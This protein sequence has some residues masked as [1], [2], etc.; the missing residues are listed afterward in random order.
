MDTG[1][2]AKTRVRSGCLTCRAR[3]IKCDESKPECHR[4]RASHV[5]CLGY[6]QKRRVVAAR[7]RA[8]RTWPPEG[9][10]DTVQH[11]RDKDSNESHVSLSALHGSTGLPLVCLPSNPLPY[12]RPHDSARHILA[13]HQYIFRTVSVLAPPAHLFWWRDYL[14]QQAWELEHLYN[15]II[16]LGTIHRAVVLASGEPPAS[17]RHGQDTTINAIRTYTKAPEQLA[18]F[19]GENGP[20]ISTVATT[21]LLAYFEVCIQRLTCQVQCIEAKSS[22]SL[23]TSSRHIDISKSQTI[24]SLLFRF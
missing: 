21:L 17:Q 12:Q 16:A 7:S 14:C 15:A 22:V 24:M 20:D 4:C 5:E 6:E 11:D 13:Y 1:R 3:R 8:L 23:G 19:L 2:D 10:D 18:S 9:D